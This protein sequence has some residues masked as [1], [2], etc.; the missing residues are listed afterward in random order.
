MGLGPDAALSVAFPAFAI[1]NQPGG[2]VRTDP[3][4][5]GPIA[6]DPSILSQSTC[7]IPATPMAGSPTAEA[8]VTGTPVAGC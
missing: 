7:P 8:D 2:I 6:I 4:A 1:D 5:P 3:S